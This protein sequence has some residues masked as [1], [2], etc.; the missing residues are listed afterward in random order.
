MEC[1]DPIGNLIGNAYHSIKDNKRLFEQQGLTLD[2][3]L[4]SDKKSVAINNEDI[5]AVLVEKVRF[6]GTLKIIKNE[7]V[8][9]KG[10]LGLGTP[11]TKQEKKTI[12]LQIP[13]QHVIPLAHAL[14]QT[15]NK[16]FL[17][18]ENREIKPIPTN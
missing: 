15:Y 18:I 6:G 7:M 5:K 4:A 8:T 12:E 2:E 11:T 16:K 13:K 10:F 9:K 17:Y 1:G 3:L 14:K